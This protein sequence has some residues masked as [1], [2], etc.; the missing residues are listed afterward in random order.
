MEEPPSTPAP[1]AIGA[2]AEQAAEQLERGSTRLVVEARDDSARKPRTVSIS[3]G[4]RVNAPESKQQAAARELAVVLEL[5]AGR[6]AASRVRQL[7][8]ELELQNRRAAET[9]GQLQRARAATAAASE[10]HREDLQRLQA[11]FE[12]RCDELSQELA[13]AKRR[14]TSEAST[15]LSSSWFSFC[16]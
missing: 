12:R 10:R 7:Q 6:D 11:Q 2:A 1:A 3:K 4:D 9:E 15:A 8:G 13:E 14:L 16:A 5:D